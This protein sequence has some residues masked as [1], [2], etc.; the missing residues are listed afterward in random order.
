MSCV[1]WRSKTTPLLPLTMSTMIK[2]ITRGNCQNIF[3]EGPLLQKQK[4]ITVLE[5]ASFVIFLKSL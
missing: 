4:Q 2:D 1:V 5:G 3:T